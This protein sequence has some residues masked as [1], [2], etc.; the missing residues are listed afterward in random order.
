[1]FA[2]HDNIF[3]YAPEW[4]ALIDPKA[5]A[6]YESQAYYAELTKVI[7]LINALPKGGVFHFSYNWLKTHW[8]LS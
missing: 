1:M 6:T 8:I 5:E 7:L 2:K 4:S 3:V